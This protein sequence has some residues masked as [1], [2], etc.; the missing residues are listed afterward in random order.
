MDT[1][2]DIGRA[3]ET[4]SSWCFLS[5]L[6][7]PFK[8]LTGSVKKLDTHPVGSGGSADI[9]AGSLDE[10]QLISKP[11]PKPPHQAESRTLMRAEI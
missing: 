6:K 9:Y 3:G 10:S 1:P 5:S 2:T 8:D 11:T 7:H 4:L